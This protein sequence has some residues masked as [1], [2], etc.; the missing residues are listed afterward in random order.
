MRA[1]ESK[2]ALKSTW[3]ATRAAA[4]VSPRLAGPVAAR[5]WF[6]PWRVP[7]GARHAQ[8][9]VEWLK[10]TE[11]VSFDVAGRRIAGFSAGAGPVV[12]LVHGWGESAASLGAFVAPLTAAGYRVVGIDA[13]AHGSSPGGRTDAYEVAAAIR[14]VSDALGGARAVVAHSAGASAAL[15]AAREGLEVGA[16]VTIAPSVRL[17]HALVTFARLFSLPADAVTGLKATIDRRYGAEVWGKFAGHEIARDL[18]VPGLIVHDREDPQVALA[19]SEALH[20]AWAGSRLVTTEGLGHG[21]ILREA[22]VLDAV[23][24]FLSEVVPARSHVG[25]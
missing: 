18:D 11:S 13:P 23:T 6:T 5:L 22:K 2:L 7:V 14:G 12:L 1:S 19:D 20:E 8:R 16:L 3:L 21:R 10:D 9:Q 15:Y 4:A 17:D 25:A 24:S